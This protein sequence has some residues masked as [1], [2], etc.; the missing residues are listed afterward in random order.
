M[1]TAWTVQWVVI[2]MFKRWVLFNRHKTSF[3]AYSITHFSFGG[4]WPFVNKPFTLSS[5]VLEIHLLK[6]IVTGKGGEQA[7][8]RSGVLGAFFSPQFHFFSSFTWLIDL[9][10]S[11]YKDT[12]S[13]GYVVRWQ[14]IYSFTLELSGL[15]FNVCHYLNRNMSLHKYIVHR[16][17]P[18][19]LVL[20]WMISWEICNEKTATVSA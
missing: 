14:I 7:L 16:A 6:N 18:P 9:K 15:V 11:M 13:H 10:M 12:A 20:R 19:S 17:L 4:N 8:L 3:T 2:W 1:T 5:E